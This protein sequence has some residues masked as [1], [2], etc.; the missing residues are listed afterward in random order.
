[1]VQ[2]KAPWFHSC[3]RPIRR[4]NKKIILVIV[5]VN[6]LEIL[7]III[8]GKINAI[9]TSKIKKIIVIKKNWIEKGSREEFIGSNPHSKGDLFSRS[10]KVFFDNKDAKIIIIIEINKINID[11]FN[12]LIIIYINFF[13]LIDWKSIILFILYKFIC[14]KK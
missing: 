1:M 14:K 10:L 9:S 13:E 4:I 11:I 7:K 3:K 8:I 2:F 12:K 6:M 5:Q